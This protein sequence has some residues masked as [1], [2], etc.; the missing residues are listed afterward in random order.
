M[1]HNELQGHCQAYMVH[2]MMTWLDSAKKEDTL[3]EIPI[4]NEASTTWSEIE[5][6]LPVPL[7][8]PW[9]WKL[10]P[11]II[12]VVTGLSAIAFNTFLFG[13]KARDQDPSHFPITIEKLAADTEVS[14]TVGS[15]H[16]GLTSSKDLKAGLLR[17]QGQTAPEVISLN[18]Q[19]KAGIRQLATNNVGDLY[20]VRA[21]DLRQGPTTICVFGADTTSQLHILVNQLQD[22]LEHLPDSSCLTI[23]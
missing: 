6:K 2:G 3:D 14:G 12:I 11:L 13:W 18:I 10:I 16:F 4:Q 8:S 7:I 22:L 20:S 21:D 19:L 23:P 17:R 5:Q 15:W 1:H 9:F